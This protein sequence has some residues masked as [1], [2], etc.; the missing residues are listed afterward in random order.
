VHCIDAADA[1]DAADADAA[2][3]DADAADAADADIPRDLCFDNKLYMYHCNLACIIT[4]TTTNTQNFPNP[5]RKVTN[6]QQ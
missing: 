3:A 1:A 6:Q 2:D 4:T 5:F